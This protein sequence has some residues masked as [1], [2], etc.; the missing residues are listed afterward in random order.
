MVFHWL[1]LTHVWRYA[2]LLA[3]SEL[4]LLTRH[5]QENTHQT[6]FLVRGWSLGTRLSN[7]L[8]PQWIHS[9][10]WHH[11][12]ITAKCWHHITVTAQWNIDITVKYWHHSDSTV[13]YWHHTVAAKLKFTFCLHCTVVLQYEPSSKNGVKF[14]PRKRSMH[15]FYGFWT[16]ETHVYRMSNTVHLVICFRPTVSLADSPCPTSI[17]SQEPEIQLATDRSSPSPTQQT[18]SVWNQH[19][20]ERFFLILENILST[21]L[22]YRLTCLWAKISCVENYSLRSKPVIAESAIVYT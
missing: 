15:H 21:G 19:I 11:S 16:G 13:K 5:S 8:V 6:L 4:R 17:A 2:I 12:D 22:S 9:D 10:I 20:S 3:C 14:L 7:T 1:T 18:Y